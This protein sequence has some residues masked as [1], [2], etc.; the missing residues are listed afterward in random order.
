VGIIK[1]DPRGN[2]ALDQLEVRLNGDPFTVC[3]YRKQVNKSPTETKE[4]TAMPDMNAKEL[5]RAARQL[6]IDGWEKMSL[7][8]L[9]TA[10]AD[11]GAPTTKEDKPVKKA[12]PKKAAGRKS[13]AKSAKKAAPAKKAAAKAEDNG[14]VEPAANGNPFAPGTNLFE[15]T[16]LLIAGGKRSDMV[17]KLK[18]KIKIAPRSTKKDWDEDAELD[19]RILIVGQNLTNQHGFNVVRD[20]R[21]AD[22]HIV[23][24]APNA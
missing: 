21:G 23:A 13:A 12:A 19:R 17:K 11:S 24:E 20:G 14:A 9:R 18:K 22:A 7:T 10:V 5:R 8:E 15:I 4:T 3:V 16:E 1:E 2:S 6:K